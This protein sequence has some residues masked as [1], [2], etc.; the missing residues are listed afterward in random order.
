MPLAINHTI[1]IIAITSIISFI[2]FSSISLK[3]QL[4]FTPY[5]ISKGQIYRLITH[6]FI[7]ADTGHLFFNMFT[8]YFFGSIMERLY[9]QYLGGLGFFTFYISAII[10][11]IIPT[12]ITQRNNYNYASLGASGAVSAVLFAFILIAPWE[13]LYFFAAIPIPAIVFAGLYVAYSI[14]AQQRARDNINHSAHLWGAAYG[15]GMTIFLRPD[16]ATRF[17]Q[18]LFNPHF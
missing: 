15:V 10:V 18:Q 6:G 4:I 1:I 8:L 5:A 11:A 16:F 7:H 14:Y 2:A 12:Y 17:I 13:K 3:R 9:N